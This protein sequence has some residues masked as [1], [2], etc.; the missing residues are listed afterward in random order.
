MDGEGAAGR[1]G[2]G[3]ETWGAV[4]S[5]SAARSTRM[6]HEL[7][8]IPAVPHHQ[9][10]SFPW[11]RIRALAWHPAELC[12]GSEGH[13]A[14]RLFLALPEKAA[15]GSPLPNS[16]GTALVLCCCDLALI[17]NKSHTTGGE[18]TKALGKSFQ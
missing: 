14:P 4:L 15:C 17:F 7:L 13:P 8:P 9:C 12:C 3:E 1:H 2:A 11:D 10:Q 16:Q 5:A 6:G 18:C